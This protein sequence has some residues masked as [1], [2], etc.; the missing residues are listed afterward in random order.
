MP[1][2][3]P[4]PAFLGLLMLLTAG[5]GCRLLAAPFIL[6]GEEPTEEVKAEWP[7]L[8]G[9]H[10]AILIWADS[11]TRFEYPN[12]GLELAEHLR[13]AMEPHLTGISFVPARDI[14]EYQRNNPDWD[15]EDP[16]TLGARFR[17]DRVMLVELTQYTT[18]EPEATH[19]LRGLIA[20]SIKLYDCGLPASEAVYRTTVETVYPD[21]GASTW[22]TN[23]S[24]LRLATMEAYSLTVARKFYDHK[25]KV[26]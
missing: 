17:A 15:L 9:K 22:G 6:F 20:S 19:L 12:V 10:V 18:R 11:N 2:K 26:K 3:H 5:V 23:E 25:V 13:V 14:V 1:G 16:S 8:S 21:E 4:L 7:H 24:D